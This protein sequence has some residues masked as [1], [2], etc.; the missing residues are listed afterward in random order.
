MASYE[1]FRHLQPKLWAKEGPGVKLAIR[2]LT[3]KSRESTSSQCPILECN[4]TLKSSRGEL[5]LW[6]KPRCDRTLQSGVRSSQSPRTPTGTISG[7]QL[8]SPKKKSHLDVASA[9]SC[10]V[11]Y[12]GE[13]GGF[14]RVRAVVSLVSQV[15]VACPN[16]QGCSRM[17]INPLWLVFEC[18]FKLDN[19]VPLPS[20]ISGLLT[21]P[22]T[23]F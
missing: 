1:P 2:L 10:R 5:K 19:L 6:F 20:L 8:G 4:T 16:T 22:S 11:Y 12:M 14:P 15:P 23:P 18:K 17:L 3:S 13:G 21:C 9:E 7:F